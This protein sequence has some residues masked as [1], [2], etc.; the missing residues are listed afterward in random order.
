MKMS[1]LENTFKIIKAIPSYPSAYSLR[2]KRDLHLN[3]TI[4]SGS[5]GEQ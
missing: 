2:E 5:C 3:T 4:L 1:T